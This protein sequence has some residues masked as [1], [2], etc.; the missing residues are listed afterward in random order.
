MKIHLKKLGNNLKLRHP[1]RQT[2]L[3]F[4]MLSDRAT[5][6]TGVVEEDSVMLKIFLDFLWSDVKKNPL[7]LVPF[8]S[9]MDSRISLLTDGVDID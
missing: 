3:G 8:T 5:S 4:N 7:N 6:K 1:K 9:E 2:S